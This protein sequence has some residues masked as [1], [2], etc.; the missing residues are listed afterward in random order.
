MANQQLTID[1]IQRAI[2]ATAPRVRGR[3][4]QKQQ[5]VIA[6]LLDHMPQLMLK[7]E[8]NTPLRAAHFIAQ[9]AHESDGFCT[10]EEY[11]SGRAYEGRKD[12]GNTKPGYGV[13]YKG[14]AVLQCTGY[15]NYKFYGNLLDLD[16]VGRPELLLE[17]EHSCAFTVAYWNQHK[18][19]TYA[20]NNDIRKVTRKINGGYNGLRDRMHYFDKASKIL[21]VRNDKPA[22]LKRGTKGADVK[23]VQKQLIAHG[24]NV[25]IVDG[26]FGKQTDRA[27]R[28][29]Q[30][31][32]G[33]KVDGKILVDGVTWRALHSEVEANGAH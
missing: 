3:K 23:A 6:G 14:R 29:F 8:I 13:L 10:N 28:V 12:L 26:D 5:K 16:L 15:Y 1:D 33:L 21:G 32:R 18:L 4:G 22:L 31:D 25:G 11:A 9:I 19:N 20:D 7:N 17:A 30:S 27:V 24:Y 2:S